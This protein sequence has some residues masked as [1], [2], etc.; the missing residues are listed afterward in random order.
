VV[1]LAA[2]AGEAAAGIEQLAEHLLHLADVAADGDAPAELLLEVGRGRQVV[3][4]GMGFQYPFD[5][6]PSARTRAISWSALA[7]LVRPDLGS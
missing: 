3:G 2:I 4:V 1:E 7:V 5:P 6:A